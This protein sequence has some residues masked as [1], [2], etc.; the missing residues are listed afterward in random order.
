MSAEIRTPLTETQRKHLEEML[1]NQPRYVQKLV[2]HVLKRDRGSLP[3]SKKDWIHDRIVMRLMCVARAWDPHREGAAALHN[4]AFL[5]AKYDW[6]G[7][8]KAFK[9]PKNTMVTT[10]ARLPIPKIRQKTEHGH[11]EVSVDRLS[12]LSA[13]ERD[14]I[15]RRYGGESLAETAAAYGVT[16]PKIREIETKALRKLGAIKV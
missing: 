5:F 8:T 1:E 12:V 9:R 15:T 10:K 3:S 16:R 4:L 6:A 7:M 14:V 2:G 11:F 13:K